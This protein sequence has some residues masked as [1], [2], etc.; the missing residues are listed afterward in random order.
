MTFGHHPS[1]SFL[2][3][4]T[5]G[6]HPS[7]FGL[8]SSTLFW[9]ASFSF[10]SSP[11][12][13]R[14]SS[15]QLSVFALNLQSASLNLSASPPSHLRLQPSPSA[16][17]LTFGFSPH[18]RPQP[19]PLARPH[20]RPQSRHSASASTF[21]RPYSIELALLRFTVAVAIGISCTFVVPCMHI[22]YH[23]VASACILHT[24]R[25]RDFHGLCL[26]GAH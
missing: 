2:H 21:V 9:S 3:P 22:I 13:P 15:P 14:S 7:T 6:L 12:D 8:H 10:W 23:T 20:L 17:D 16:S 25:I 1:T 26:S 18:L 24:K 19:R 11:F 4:S 5:F